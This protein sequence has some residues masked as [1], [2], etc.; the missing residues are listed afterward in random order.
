MKR[1]TDRILTTHA[2]SL[3]RPDDLRELVTAKANKE[4]YDETRFASR[5]KSA[6]GEV[7]QQQLKNGVDVLNDGEF[8]KSNF[9]NYARERL[10]G[11]EERTVT[12][13]TPRS[14]RV[15]NG[16]GVSARPWQSRS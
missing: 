5:V 13:V 11:F 3:P 14:R 6:V 12:P 15:P 1:S 16:S 9:S 8:G 4:P 2:G 10:G 7:V